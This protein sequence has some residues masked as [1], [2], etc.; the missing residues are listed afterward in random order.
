MFCRK[1][2]RNWRTC[3]LSTSP[4]LGLCISRENTHHGFGLLSIL[5]LLT[6]SLK[7]SSSGTTPLN[8][9]SNSNSTKHMNISCPTEREGAWRL[10]R[11]ETWSA[12]KEMPGTKGLY[13]ELWTT[14]LLEGWPQRTR[15]G[16]TGQRPDCL[17][18]CGFNTMFD[19][20]LLCG[21]EGLQNHLI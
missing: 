7:S 16:E 3:F 17:W 4:V 13:A 5:W 11:T 8:C 14:A 9:A 10:R 6:W 20:V 21:S 15:V 19:Y 1:Q 12:A 18:F 2:F